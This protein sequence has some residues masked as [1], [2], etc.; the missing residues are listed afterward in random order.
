MNIKG[1]EI[2]KYYIES[3]LRAIKYNQEVGTEDSD[4]MQRKTHEKIFEVVGLNRA[5]VS[6]EDREFIRTLDDITETLLRSEY[7]WWNNL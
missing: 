2:D 5:G 4:R 6:R 7:K 3:Y 1:Y